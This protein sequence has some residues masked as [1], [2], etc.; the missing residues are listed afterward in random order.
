MNKKVI[1]VRNSVL[2]ETT[3][4]AEDMILSLVYLINEARNK[5]DVV[6]VS[7]I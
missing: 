5:Y 3:N 4:I 6:L 7:Y 2:A 1:K